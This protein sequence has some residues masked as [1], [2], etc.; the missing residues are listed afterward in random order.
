MTSVASIQTGPRPE[1][2]Q[3]V[4]S[5]ELESSDGRRWRAIGGGLSRREALAFAFDSTP[6]GADWRAV[7]VDDLYGD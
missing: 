5:V 7:R 2:S 3:V 1:P 6:A 4:L